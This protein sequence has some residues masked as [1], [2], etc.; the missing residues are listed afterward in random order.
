L[1][2]I[3]DVAQERTGEVK[4][5]KCEKIGANW[6]SFEMK[7]QRNNNNTRQLKILFGIIIIETID[8]K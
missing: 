6:E 3:A 4:L 1:S 7:I 5:R 2:R 8:E